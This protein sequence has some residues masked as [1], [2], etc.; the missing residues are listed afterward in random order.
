M[1]SKKIPILAT[2]IQM[3]LQSI[4]ISLLVIFL[5]EKA[6]GIVLIYLILATLGF[7]ILAEGISNPHWYASPAAGY[8]VGFLISSFLLAKT[9]LIINPQLFFNAWLSLALNETLILFCG[10][11]FLSFHIGPAQAWWVGVFPYLI[12]AIL[13]ITIAT[14]VYLIKLRFSKQY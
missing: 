1:A 3:S 11:I 6:F 5:G 14:F 12:G 10:Y 9:L 8:Y 2:T 4:S 7:P 13:K